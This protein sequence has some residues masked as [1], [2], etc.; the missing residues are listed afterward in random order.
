MKTLRIVGLLLLIIILLV[1]GYG[2]T[3]SGESYLE[4]SITLNAS[5]EKVFNELNSFKTLTKWSPLTKIDPETKYVYSGPEFGV[6]ARYEW[7]SD[8]P[9]V[10]QGAQQITES[11]EN[12]YIKTK[13]E[14]AID[15]WFTAEFILEPKDDKTLLTWTY[16]SKVES[17]M[18]KYIMLGLEGRLGP[19]YERGLKDFK[20]YVENLPDPE[21]ET[22][23][24]EEGVESESE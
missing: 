3:L 15:G 22:E 16:D 6:D 8:H 18:W 17:L 7:E 19:V 10:R 5:S 1:V 24:V 11:V 2:M 13:M 12:K 14:F 9:D 21:P 23:M 4:R 20:Y